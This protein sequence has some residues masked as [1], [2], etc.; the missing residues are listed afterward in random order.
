MIW[1]TPAAA[2]ALLALA[3]PVLVHTLVRRRAKPTP[4]PTLR[5][6]PHTRLA[7]IERRALE[8]G[9]LL[10][11][12]LGVIAAAA[13]A[14]ASPFVVTKSRRAA[15]NAVT[16]RAEVVAGVPSHGDAD[17]SFVAETVSQGIG[18]ALAWLE[19][20]PPGRR[21]LIVRSMF[22]VG[23]V[24]ASEVAA[25]PADIGL[26]FER[27][28][29][30]PGSSRL[31]APAVLA[32]DGP[33]SIFRV[34]RETMLVGDRT[35]VRDTETSE[36]GV[37]PIE[38]VAPVSRRESA[39]EILNS[40][41]AH[42]VPAP[43]GGRTARIE[44]TDGLAAPREVTVENISTAWM[45]DAV[46]AIWRDMTPRNGL[47]P[48][49]R[50]R[51]EG[52]RLIIRA[53]SSISDSVLSRLATSILAAIG[54]VAGQPREDILPIP[55]AQLKAWSREPGPAVVPPAG[56]RPWDGR[57]FW[58]LALL[59]LGAEALVRRRPLRIAVDQPRVAER[60]HVA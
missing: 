3:L 45:A 21:Q 17:R 27:A 40:A 15:W 13:A 7:S 22:P 18:Q 24:S 19:V 20:Q 50:F 12:R 52:S 56:Q 54:P 14:I 9:A 43:S 30:L 36:A 46:A 25:V 29:T 4:F 47:T 2:W 28:G 42:R 32:R 37:V 16:I 49:L 8:D 10:A 55:E 38:I 5:F 23:S 35:S 6:I 11:I 33:N 57:W 48:G 53:D 34:Q 59:L 51:S 44:L 31:K 60:A 41:L 39:E 1:G 26:T 58:L